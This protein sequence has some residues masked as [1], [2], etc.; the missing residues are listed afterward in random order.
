MS[1]GLDG[2]TGGYLIGWQNSSQFVMRPEKVAD[3]FRKGEVF[4]EHGAKQSLRSKYENIL[5]A[6][7]LKINKVKLL[8]YSI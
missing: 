1:S 6:E 8:A 5:A 2:E 3:A 7:D 4:G